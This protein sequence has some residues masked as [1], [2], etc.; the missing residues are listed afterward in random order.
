MTSNR[1]SARLRSEVMAPRYLAPPTRL[2]GRQVLF[3]EPVDLRSQRVRRSAAIEMHVARQGAVLIGCLGSDALECLLSGQSPARLK[4][5][6]AHVDG[7]LNAHDHV[8]VAALAGL[9]EQRDVV[10]SHPNAIS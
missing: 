9:D 10:H 1:L 7:R 5:C 4:P 8:E 3:P 2:S 6:Q